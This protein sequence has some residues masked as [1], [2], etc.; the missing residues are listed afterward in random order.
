M[1]PPVDELLWEQA[2]NET[3]FDDALN[4]VRYGDANAIE[5]TGDITLQDRYRIRSAWDLRELNMNGY[6]IKLTG[7]PLTFEADNTEVTKGEIH[8]QIDE[9]L[10]LERFPIA[11]ADALSAEASNTIIP[12]FDY[13]SEFY[14]ALEHNNKVMVDGDSVT[15]DGITFNVSLRD[16]YQ[17]QPDPATNL[18][19]T[20]CNIHHPAVFVSDVTM[21]DTTI[22]SKVGFEHDDA[23]LSNITVAENPATAVTHDDFWDFLWDDQEGIYGVLYI[24]GDVY[25]TDISWVDNF[26]GIFV[27]KSL[28][29]YADGNY[30]SKSYSPAEPTLNGAEIWTDKYGL[31]W[32]AINHDKAE[33]NATGIVEVCSDRGGPGLMLVGTDARDYGKPFDGAYDGGAILGDATFSSNDH[34][35][36]QGDIWFGKPT[37]EFL[38][39]GNGKNYEGPWELDGEGD[40]CPVCLEEVDYQVCYKDADRLYIHGGHNFVSDVFIF[41]PAND[42]ITCEETPNLAEVSNTPEETVCLADPVW[43]GDVNFGHVSLWGDFNIVNGKTV[44]FDEIELKCGNI[45]RIGTDRDLGTKEDC[46]VTHPDFTRRGI[47]EGGDI[48]SDTK[49]QN[50]LVLGDGL[51]LENVDLT[52]TLYNVILETVYLENVDINV[53]ESPTDT[54]EREV[55][56][57]DLNAAGYDVFVLWGNHATFENVTLSSAKLRLERISCPSYAPTPLPK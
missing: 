15:F 35:G 43:L 4:A 19:V 2:G 37:V 38:T 53:G 50:V 28:K 42:Y 41:T 30:T 5:L 1:Q 56:G 8:G 52:N 49:Y 23:I 57:Y 18:T 34:K 6:T 47:L 55:C 3:E 24:N 11:G 12:I 26:T 21:T 27:G 51:R 31:V 40:K 44:T 22:R 14:K 25:M 16:W 7:G 29:Y 46:T 36:D 20:G 13:W 9:D 45:R 17:E 48:A 10:F 32:W 39:E 54:R 33:L